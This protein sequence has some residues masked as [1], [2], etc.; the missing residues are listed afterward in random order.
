MTITPL[1][2]LLFGLLPQRAAGQ[3][4]PVQ[5]TIACQSELRWIN[6]DQKFYSLANPFQI[7]L[8]SSTGIGCTPAE[9]RV[10]AIYLDNDENVVCS[11]VVDNVAQQDQNTQSI[12]LEFKPL[13]A[14]EF[15][16]W[17]N[18]LRPPQPIAKRLVCIGPDQLTEASRNETD[19]AASVRIIITLLPRNGGLSNLEIKVDPRR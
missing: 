8:F 7:N 9:V 14:L 18:G 17:R 2:F 13:I 19:R 10:T 16:R 15:V 3:G 12:V 1:F 11:G 5:A 6:N 4:A